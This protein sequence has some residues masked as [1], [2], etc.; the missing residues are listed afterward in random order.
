MAF[1][2]RNELKLFNW[3]TQAERENHQHKRWSFCNIQL[4]KRMVQG[5]KDLRYSQTLLM[6][7]RPGHHHAGEMKI[8]SGWN[9]GQ[10]RK[11]IVILI[12]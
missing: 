10:V 3:Q 11:F 6:E 9:K 8:E 12:F 2:S 1:N 5:V 4:S 7:S